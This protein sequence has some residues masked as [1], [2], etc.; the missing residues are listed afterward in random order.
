MA[1]INLGQAHTEEWHA[2][3]RT[4]V[5]ASRSSHL[6]CPGLPWGVTAAEL[7]SDMASGGGI[8]EREMMAAGSYFELA[9]MGWLSHC[10]GAMVEPDGALWYDPERPWMGA[11]PDAYLTGGGPAP[12]LSWEPSLVV[13][14]SWGEALYGDE[15]AAYVRALPTHTLLEAKQ[16]KSAGRSK[17]KKTAPP[18]HYYNQ[19]QH[20]MSVLGI[21]NNLLVAKVDAYEL[22]AF[23]IEKSDG[24]CE[25][26]EQECKAFWEKYLRKG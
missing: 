11:S 1:L 20:Q 13:R 4:M 10:T 17:W 9:N 25:L 15:A 22:W 6:M 23:H 26:L 12:D 14:D 19:A 24:Y 21:D 2:A 5:T 3:R 16:S 7:A 8:V 18:D